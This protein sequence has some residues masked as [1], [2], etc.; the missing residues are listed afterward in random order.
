MRAALFD[1]TFGVPFPLPTPQGAGIGNSGTSPRP[2]FESCAR[3][4][5]GQEANSA[6]LFRKDCQGCNEARKPICPAPHSIF[7]D[8]CHLPTMTRL[9]GG[10]ARGW[11]RDIAVRQMY[12][13]ETQNLLQYL[14]Q[15]VHNVAWQIVILLPVTLSA[16]IA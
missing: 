6:N 16:Q 13:G 11:K 3:H 14:L 8:D 9:T 10:C 2:R 4:P 1:N 5:S 7:R 15:M 12:K